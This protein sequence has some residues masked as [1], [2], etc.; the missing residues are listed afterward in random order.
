MKFLWPDML[1][2]LLTAPVMVAGYVALLR[3]R[4]KRALRYASLG[5]VKEAIGPGQRF[6]RHVPPLL[7]L[8]S[9]IALII[10]IAGPSAVITLPSQQQTIVL[11]MDVSLSMG[12]RDVDPNRI[13]AAQAAAKQFIEDH[14]LD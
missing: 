5:I 12:A 13:T 14:P 3:R 10:A 7:F 2:L 8:L 11:A 9:V 4:K 1:W 6:R